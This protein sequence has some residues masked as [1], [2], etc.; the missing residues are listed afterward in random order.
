[1]A[2]T[3]ADNWEKKP[4]LPIYKNANWY[5]D[6]KETDLP[7]DFY[8]SKFLVDKAIEFIDSNSDDEKPFFAYIPFQ[9]VHTPV[10]A[11]QEFID[12]YMGVY[13]QGWEVLRA[14]RQARAVE[15]GLVP[16]ETPM[17]DMATTAD[18]DLLTSEEKRYQS[19]RMAVYGA[20]VEAMDHHIGRLIAHLK[21]TGQFENTIFIF[22]SDNGSEATGAQNPDT[23]GARLL[24][25]FQGYH[26][27]YETLGLKG[28]FNAIGPSFA[29]ASASPLAFYKFFSGEGG[30]RVPLIVSGPGVS[31]MQ[32][33]INAFTYVTDIAPTI[34]QLTGVRAQGT[35]YG[36]RAVEPMIGRSLVPLVNGTAER[37]YFEDDAVGYEIGGNAALF[38]G[39][40]KIMINR[41]PVGDDKWHLYD[42]VNDP[43][44]TND[45]AD[46][47]PL[48]A[49]SML[50]AYEEYVVRNNVL[51]VPA[52]FDQRLQALVNG[53]RDRYRLQ[54]LLFI[55]TLVV[56]IPFYVVHRRLNG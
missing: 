55:L 40:F 42:I 12:R 13:D 27:D 33:P 28:S 38:Q 51:P 1:M 39:D 18:W 41:G 56:L 14:E 30:M 47:M 43:G 21:E 44:E 22:T 5:A 8:S 16:G 11:P 24:L 36:G 37:I 52:G 45:L 49:Q 17:V 46:V 2:D 35:H 48:R 10:Q 31:S 6:G 7:E 54:I 32:L 19:K 53:I 3:G 50:A 20:M 26:N 34:L 9:A 29:S 23:I 4:Y 25:R 15:L